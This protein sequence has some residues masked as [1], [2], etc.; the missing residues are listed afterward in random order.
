MSLNGES[1]TFEDFDCVK[2]DETLAH[3]YM[4]SCK[5][6]GVH[7]KINSLEAIRIGL[8]GYLKSPSVNREID[9]IKES[10]F[11]DSNTSFKAVLSDV[12]RRGG[13]GVVNYPTISDADS[14]Y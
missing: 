11:T 3:L 6:D 7:Y 1:Q 2:P 8:N 5:E 10:F 12:K 14:K 9:I 13:G 4:D